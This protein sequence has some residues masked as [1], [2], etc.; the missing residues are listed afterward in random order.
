M[1]ILSS[2]RILCCSTWHLRCTSYQLTS[3]QPSY[4]Q[5]I[6]RGY[7]VATSA[8]GAIG[9][10]SYQQEELS[11]GGYILLLKAIDPCAGSS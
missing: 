9:R 3:Y 4:Q 1:K 7:T 11:A 8:Q 6:Y 10:R 2:C 5:R